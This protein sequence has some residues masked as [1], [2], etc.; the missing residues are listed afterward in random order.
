MIFGR[1]EKWIIVIH[2]AIA[3]DQPVLL[4]TGVVLQAGS[5]VGFVSNHRH[6]EDQ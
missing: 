5:R 6:H 3:T 1:K 2:I 4:Q